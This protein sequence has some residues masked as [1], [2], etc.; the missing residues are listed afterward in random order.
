MK[1]QH[2]LMS[3]ED[4]GDDNETDENADKDDK[5]EKGDG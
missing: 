2:Y 5:K 1:H 3:R 4:D